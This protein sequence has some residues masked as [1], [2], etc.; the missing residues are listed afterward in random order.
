VTFFENKLKILKILFLIEKIRR[1]NADFGLSMKE[2]MQNFE[3]Y[4]M[5]SKKF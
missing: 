3:L 2:Y 5:S 1:L 4:S